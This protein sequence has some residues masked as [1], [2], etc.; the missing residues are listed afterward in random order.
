MPASLSRSISEA[1]EEASLSRL[2]GGI[3]FT[4]GNEQGRIMGRKIGAAV[5]SK[6]QTY[7]QGRISGD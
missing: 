3:H 2:Y 4:D 5:W 7:F 1:A 6:A